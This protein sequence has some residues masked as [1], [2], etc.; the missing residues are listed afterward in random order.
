MKFIIG[1]KVISSYDLKSLRSFISYVPQNPFLFS[2]TIIENIKFG[3]FYANKDEVKKLQKIPQFIQIYPGSKIN[4]KQY[5]ERG[6]KS[7]P[8]DK[9]RELQ[10]LELYLKSQEILILDDCLSSVDAKTE[11]KSFQNKKKKQMRQ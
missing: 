11:R 8:V 1:D 2:D 9:F 5:W 7:Y 6:C 3:N 10:L 4:T